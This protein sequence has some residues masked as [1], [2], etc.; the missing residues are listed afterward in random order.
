LCFQQRRLPLDGAGETLY[1]L[2]GGVR[3]MNIGASDLPSAPLIPESGNYFYKIGINP[4]NSDIFITDAV[5]Y[6]QQGYVLYYKKNGTLVSIQI[7]D[8][9]P[10][11]MCFKLNENF[12]TK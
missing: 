11:S 6:Q 7:A 12:Q 10:G 2:D 4:V 9:I 5:D 1:Y 8:I 3:R